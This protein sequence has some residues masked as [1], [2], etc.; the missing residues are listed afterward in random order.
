MRDAATLVRDQHILL[1]LDGLDEMDPTPG[2]TDA[3]AEN[4]SIDGYTDRHDRRIDDGPSGHIGDP[5]A[6]PVAFRHTVDTDEFSVSAHPRPGHRQI[7]S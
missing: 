2:D 5:V 7:A 6:Q 1:I 4:Q 3:D